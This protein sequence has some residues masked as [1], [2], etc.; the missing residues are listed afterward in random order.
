MNSKFHRFP[1]RNNNPISAAS[2]NRKNSQPGD[3][4]H[5]YDYY[6]QLARGPGTGDAV[7][8]EQH[9]QHAEHFCRLLNGSATL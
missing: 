7:A 1:R 5:S 2:V 3:W 9:W 4:Q 8:R 6:C